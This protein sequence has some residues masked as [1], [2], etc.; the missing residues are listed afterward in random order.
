MRVPLDRL[1]ALHKTWRT[2]GD[3]A[4]LGGEPQDAYDA[5]DAFTEALLAAWPEIRVALAQI[6]KAPAARQTATSGGAVDLNDLRRWDQEMT[7]APWDPADLL[8]PAVS[9][10]AT[11]GHWQDAEATAALRNR[12]PD[13]IAA[14]ETL[15]RERDRWQA[16]AE[17]TA[18]LYET[19]VSERDEA[20]SNAVDKEGTQPDAVPEDEQPLP[21]QLR[22]SPW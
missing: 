16:R 18:S 17:G 19:A 2:A 5:R 21:T 6:R 7:P 3:A 15:T 9:E 1:D 10:F 11:G 22:G 13:I 8:D 12:L 4:Q 20:L 14:L